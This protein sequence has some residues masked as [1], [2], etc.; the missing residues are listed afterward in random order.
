MRVKIKSI[1][2]LLFILPYALSEDGGKCSSNAYPIQNVTN[3]VLNMF[4]DY[5]QMISMK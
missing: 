5:A 3:M 1:L 4:K 2:F